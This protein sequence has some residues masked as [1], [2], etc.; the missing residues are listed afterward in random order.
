M[1]LTRHTMLNCVC[2][3]ITTI[4]ICNFIGTCQ[5]ELRK[6][7]IYGTICIRTIG[8]EPYSYIRHLSA[9]ITHVVNEL[10]NAYQFIAPSFTVG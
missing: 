4:N 8:L 10:V 9:N 3:D 2:I 5:Y 6:N 1:E 7:M